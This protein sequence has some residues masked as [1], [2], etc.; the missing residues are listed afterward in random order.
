MNIAYVLIHDG[1]ADWEPASALAELRRSFG[2]SVQSIGLTEQPVTSMGGLK[3][4]PD[5]AIA[6]FKPESAAIFI[7]PGGDFWTTGEIPAVSKAVRGMSALG[8]PVAAICG[9]TLALAHCSLLDDRL[10]TSN[11]KDF[12]GKYVSGYRGAEHYRAAPAVRDRSIITA[13]GLAPFAFAAEIFR[14]LAPTQ[15]DDIEMYEKLYSRGLLD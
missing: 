7:L 9:A 11:G 4:L 2:F 1:Y 5:L 8:R 14:E 3:V 15:N 10:H 13:N 12:I 6:D